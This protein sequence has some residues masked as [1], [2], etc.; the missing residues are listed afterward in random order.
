MAN[1][2]TSTAAERGCGRS[3]GRLGEH[4]KEVCQTYLV[5]GEVVDVSAGLH[6]QELRPVVCVG[7][8]FLPVTG[9]ACCVYNCDPAIVIATSSIGMMN[10]ES[11]MDTGMSSN[12]EKKVNVNLFTLGKSK[13]KYT[14]PVFEVRRTGSV[15]VFQAIDFMS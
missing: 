4:S 11:T 9:W 14:I 1:A 13:V 6:I 3:C 12:T 15:P 2:A 10:K 7:P 8:M 5:V